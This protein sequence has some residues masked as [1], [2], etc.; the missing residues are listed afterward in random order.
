[1]NEDFE[2]AL[3]LCKLE[4]YDEAIRLF[5]QAILMN[6]DH[7]EA[8]YNRGMAKFKLRKFLDAIQD[9]DKALNLSPQ[10][11]H[12]ISQRGVAKHL[13]GR[14][15]AAMKDMDKAQALEPENAYRYTSRA[16]IRAKMGDLF[17]AVDD[18]KIALK[19]DPEDSIAWNNLGLLEE[20]MGYNQSAQDRFAQADKIA[21]KDKTFEKPDLKEILEEANKNSNAPKIQ[22]SQ[23]VEADN[24][25]DNKVLEDKNEEKPEAK[26]LT[27]KLYF[28]T[29]KDIFTSKEAFAD[30]LGFLKGGKKK[31]E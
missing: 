29:V 23:E 7:V 1:M 5:N 31:E 10:N 14:S 24:Y 26:K 2:K 13:L 8:Y 4:Q 15:D 3:N 30:F 9:F 11:A 12:I 22:L 28:Q 19:L 21:D 6:P 16:F 18:Y 27:A 25:L 17:G 20:G